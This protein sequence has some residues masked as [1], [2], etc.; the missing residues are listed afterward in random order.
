MNKPRGINALKKTKQSNYKL[1]YK[2]SIALPICIVIL[3]SVFAKPISKKLGGVALALAGASI[4][5]GSINMIKSEVS[6]E[7]EMQIESVINQSGNS[8]NKVTE[9]KKMTKDI[10][11][12]NAMS[13]QISKATPNDI[14]EIIEQAKNS[15]AAARKSGNIIEKTYGKQN[16][17][18][19]YKNISIR[20]VTDTKTVNIQKSLEKQAD[21]KIEDKSKPTVLIFHT[22][23]TESYE[24]LDRGWYSNDFPTRSKDPKKNMIRVGDAIVEKLET[25]GFVVLHDTQIYDLSYNGS[26]A[27][28]R[29]TIEKYKS[30]YPSLKVIIDVHRDGIQQSD[31]TKIKPV[32]SINNRK[33]AQIM[34]IT[35]AQDGKVTDFPD[36][37]QN[38]TFAVQ[39]QKRAEDLY[40]GL[41]R[42]IFFAPRKYNMDTSHCGILL[43]IGSDANTLEEAAYSGELI[44]VSLASLMND[45]VSK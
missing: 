31:G 2:A 40:P 37:E 6:G 15:Q 3:A 41:M 35:G 18:S 19:T 39:L 10:E 33:A 21:L 30:Q 16:S 11:N 14:L 28:S 8:K 4:P 34:I 7:S 22:H 38:L 5:E 27:R 1:R 23:T 26:Y 36:W 29:E 45:Y 13:A 25:A 12:K 20:N 44:G 17:T 9:K 24:M 42:P 32:V 43:E